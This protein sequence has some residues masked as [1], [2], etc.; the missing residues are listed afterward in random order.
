M[1]HKK[2]NT[3][4]LIFYPNQ[5]DFIKGKPVSFIV[6][7]EK[8]CYLTLLNIPEK[9]K[10]TGI[11]PNKFNQNNRIDAGV[12]YEIPG[13][14]VK[15]FTLR[16]AHTGAERIIA[17]CN[18]TRPDPI[19][20]KHN[21]RDQAYTTFDNYEQVITRGFRDRRRTRQIMV[22]PD[23]SKSTKLKTEREKQLPSLAANKKHTD[24]EARKAELLNVR[25]H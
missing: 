11:F 16:F 4:N 9:G 20:I 7:S 3:F 15:N 8:S 23:S 24:I 2:P 1:P 14:L 22:E 5:S 12:E 10:T 18:A 21:F 13:R 17:I 6:Q 19:G 25:E